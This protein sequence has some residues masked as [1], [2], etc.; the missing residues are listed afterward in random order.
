[1][2]FIIKNFDNFLT[3][4]VVNGVNTRTTRTKHQLHRPVVTLSCIQRGVFYS[5][6][7]MFNKLPPHILE[8]T[9]ILL[10]WRIWWAPNNASRWQL[11]FN[12]A[13]KGLKMRPQDLWWHWESILLLTSFILLMRFYLEVKLLSLLNINH[14]TIIIDVESL[15]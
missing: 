6:I 15:W 13:F 7:K 10:T 2:M 3:N 9:L 4:T 5:R 14:D 12:S 1:M 11:E 8:L